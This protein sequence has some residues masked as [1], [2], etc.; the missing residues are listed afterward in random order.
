M[1]NPLVSVAKGYL[2]RRGYVLFSAGELRAA[3]KV[4]EDSDKKL[5]ALVPRTHHG[6]WRIVGSPAPAEA[7]RRAC[8]QVLW[9]L[10]RAAPE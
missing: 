3:L 2:R 5:S 10:R 8:S 9:V 7:A 6:R 4:V 1:K